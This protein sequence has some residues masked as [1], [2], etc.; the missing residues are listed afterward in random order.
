MEKVRWAVIGAGGIARR[1]TIPEGIIPA[2][3][4]ELT[5]VYAPHTGHEV[6]EEFEVVAAD[7]EESLMTSHGMRFTLPVPCIVM[8]GKCFAPHTPGATSFAK[9]LSH[10]MLPK[11]NRCWMLVVGNRSTNDFFISISSEAFMTRRKL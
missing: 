9:N 3:N 6:A 11:L 1:R 2:T 4:A 8:R 5:A 10:S 7:S